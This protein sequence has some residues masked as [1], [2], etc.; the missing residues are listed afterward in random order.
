M[1][2]LL[3]SLL[4]VTA[5][6]TA[7][8]EPEWSRF[9]GPNGS[10]LAETKGLPTEFGPSLNVVWK[11]DLPQGYSSPVVH[12]DRIYLTGIRNDVPLTFAVDRRS[13]KIL[14]E[15]EAPRDRKEKLDSRNHPA[16]ASAATDGRR[17]FVFFG[18]YGL[19]AYDVNGKELWRKPLGPFNNIYGMGSSPIIV[20]NAVVIACDQ[21]TGSFIAS[22]DAASGKEQWRTPRPEAKSG[23]S[24][25][26]LY[27]PAGGK[28]QILLPGSFLLTAYAADTGARLWW[29]GGL[30]FELKSVPVILGDTLFI[31]G[32]GSNDNE[33]GRRVAVP[34]S[35]DV[36]ASSDADKNGKLTQQEAP[37]GHARRALSF[38]DL[39]G[40]K[41]L[42]V[43][44]W[45]YYKAAMDSEN[46]LI[47]IKLGGSGDMTEKSVKW[48]YR[49]AVPQLPS[50]LVYQNVL[51][52]VND[53]GIV[54]T[55]N[56]ETGA[57]IQQ[58]RLKGAI[59]AYYSSPVAADGKVYMA[60][61]KGKVSVLKPD[62]SLEPVVVNDLQDDI[63]ATP[64]LVDGRIYLRTR[65]TLYCFGK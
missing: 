23:H 48:S 28:T 63:Y 6:A 58:G 56:P 65:N 16:A 26:V 22:F 17:V 20:D 29:V 55:L 4:F 24:T 64:A 30:S 34:T 18:D 45:D 12:G 46:G 31:N 43:Q 11:V 50:P 21:S 5:F 7:A 19:L 60:S 25:P 2:T 44:E 13:G 53:G 51:Y 57:L 14:W 27:K 1:P 39:D 40:D 54:T 9:R 10:G 38:A 8:A 59:D 15:R 61:E 3:I 47:A 52:M 36:F 35:A 62:G 37:T 41:L 42:S 33:P 49:R 32:F